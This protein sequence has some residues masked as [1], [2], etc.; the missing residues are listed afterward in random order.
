M[1]LLCEYKIML[2][3]C[4]VFVHQNVVID[5]VFD[6]RYVFSELTLLMLVG[7]GQSVIP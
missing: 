5:C 6:Y 7:V 2:N 4:A 1:I 3:N